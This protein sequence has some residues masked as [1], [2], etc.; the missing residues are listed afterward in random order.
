MK[1]KKQ[2]SKK[3]PSDV[4]FKKV[5]HGV[6]FNCQHLCVDPLKPKDK[7]RFITW[8]I[9]SKKGGYHRKYWII[10]RVNKNKEVKEIKRGIDKENSLYNLKADTLNTLKAL[11]FKYYQWFI[12]QE[13]NCFLSLLPKKEEIRQ[14]KPLN[15]TNK[16]GKPK[17]ESTQ[18]G[19]L[20]FDNNE[21]LGF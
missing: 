14:K 10:F 17:K 7:Y 9:Y 21:P 15:P 13:I 12:R 3:N 16:Q 1:D 11:V 19:D 2:S 8:C 4:V 6:E 5:I 18:Q 20:F